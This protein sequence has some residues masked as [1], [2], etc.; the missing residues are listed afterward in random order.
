M[1]GKLFFILFVINLQSI[2]GQEMDYI[3]KIVWQGE[4]INTIEFLTLEEKND[5]FVA[6]G[7]IVGVVKE[8][9]INVL[10]EITIDKDWNVRTVVIK[11]QS[12]FKL[13]LFLEKDSLNRWYDKNGNHLSDYDG[14][15]NVDISLTPFT[16]TLP[17]NKFKLAEGAS[18]EVMILYIDLPKMEIKSFIQCYTNLGKNQYKYEN[19]STGFTSVI[20]VDNDGLV[21]SYPGIWKRIYP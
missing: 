17:I 13:D 7:N 16:N 8:K 1:V 3:Q 20:Q 6:K 2:K 15:T 18:K 9:P 10:Y 11:Q 5:S 19:V 14:C 21:V 12:E 4:L